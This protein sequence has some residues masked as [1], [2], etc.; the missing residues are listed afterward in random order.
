MNKNLS[1]AGIAALSLATTLPLAATENAPRK[2]FA[3]WADLPLPKQF[4]LRLAYTEGESYHIWDGNQ[5][6]NI[7]VNK[8]GED[9]GID[10][11]QGNI[12]MEYGIAKKWAADLNLGYGAVGTRSFNAG[13]N[14]EST[15]GLLDTTLGVRYQLLNEA[16]APSPWL[17]T[18]TF[19]A[20]AVFPG[21]YKKDFPFAPGNHSVAIEP[22]I[23]LKKHFAWQGFGAYGDVFYR[24][25]RSSGDDQY[26]VALGLFQEIKSWTLNAGWRHQHQLSGYNLN[27]GGVGA[28]LTYSPQ[29]REISDSVEAGFSYRLPKWDVKL[30]FYT[31]KKFD[32]SNTDSAFSVGGYVEVPFGGK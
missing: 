25:M 9:Y 29:V 6:H 2:P 24:W 7:N 4:I 15:S 32:G 5:R 13:G 21:S 11:M 20:G 31:R 28:A 3:E 10:P 19:R 27:F 8:N 23:L 26:S 12:L 14:S 1:I 16:D 18:L 17:P 30:G 22:S